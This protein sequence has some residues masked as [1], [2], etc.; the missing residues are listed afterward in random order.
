MATI[1]HRADG[2]AVRATTARSL[3]GQEWTSIDWAKSSREVQRL[4]QRIF[5]ASQQ[6]QWQKVRSLQRLLLRSDANLVLSV[7]QVTQVNKGKRTPGVDGRTATTHHERWRFLNDLRQARTNC[8]KPVRRVYIPKANGKRRPLGIPTIEDRVRQNVVK[9]ALEPAWEPHFEATSY[10]FRPGRSVHDALQYLWYRLNSRARSKW[11]LDA[12]IRGAFD[13]ISHSYILRR[14]GNFPARRQVKAW[15]EAGY[16]EF[17]RIHETTEG[18][19]QGG[20]ISPLL[21]NIALDGLG[22]YLAQYHMPG[23]KSWYYYG[24]ARYAD[25]FVITAAD[26][27]RLEQR[28]PEIRTWLAER[29]LELNEEKTRIVHVDD[30]FN[31]L[32]ATLRRYRGQLLITPQKEKVLAKLRELKGWLHHNPTV[33]SRVVVNHLSPILR[34]WAQH[35]QPLS[36]SKTYSY[37]Q[38]RLWQ[39][40]WSWARRRHPHL[41]TV[42][43]KA[44]YFHAAYGSDWVFFADTKGRH[45]DHI[46]VDLMPVRLPIIRHVLVAGN[47]SPMDPS[48]KDYWT[49]RHRVRALVRFRTSAKKR[50]IGFQQDWRCSVCRQPLLN[51]ESLDTHHRVRV[52]DGGSNRSANLEMRHE[53]CHYNSK[54]IRHSL[55]CG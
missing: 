25:D 32:G 24:Y 5:R 11:V 1:K 16:L 8:T 31:F 36:S 13:H 14:M 21:A 17:G 35:Y 47:N 50:M 54:D 19:P 44:K 46:V 29:G 3:A 22:A 33:K 41:T 4:Q 42:R 12:D 7:R 9:T 30:G 52:M 48:L 27:V 38:H 20:V 10:G 55:S 37:F 6:G 43:L 2:R 51:G 53:A 18:T 40:L 15:L 23:K 28:L 26:K 45:G 34:G 39:M 49:T